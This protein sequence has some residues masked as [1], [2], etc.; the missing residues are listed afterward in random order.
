[1]FLNKSVLPIY[2]AILS[3]ATVASAENTAVAGLFEKA[4]ALNIAAVK[5][6]GCTIFH[7]GKIVAQQASFK[8]KQPDQ[9]IIMTCEQSL[10]HSA[11]NRQAL[12]NLYAGGHMIAALE[13]PLATFEVV[14]NH[15]L[16][17]ARQYILKLGYYNNND[18]DRREDDLLALNQKVAPLE[19]RWTTEGFVGINHAMGISTPDELVIIYYDTPEIGEQFRDN[20]KDIL[21]DVGAFN[22]AHLTN[23]SYLVGIDVN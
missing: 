21:N 3:F 23:Y 18:I 17:T 13:G 16:S 2:A 7:A 22:D 9:F 8:M 15:S 1:M 10:L 12:S 19:G 20:N 5:N 4:G 14:N 11:Q 6:L